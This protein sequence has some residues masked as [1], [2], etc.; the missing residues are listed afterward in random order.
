MDTGK[1]CKYEPQYER[2]MYVVKP[3]DVVLLAGKA[4]IAMNR[5]AALGWLEQNWQKVIPVIDE[6]ITD[7]I[8]KL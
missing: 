8:N 5:E 6:F 1:D 4:G 2:A 3:D 7:E